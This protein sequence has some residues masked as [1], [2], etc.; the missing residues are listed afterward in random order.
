MKYSRFEILAMI[1]GI[2][3]V[4]GTAASSSA[5][6]STASEI[7]GQVLILVALFA[8]L[9]YGRKGALAGFLC[10]AVIYTILD[11]ATHSK[12]LGIALQLMVIRI[13]VYAL[14]AFVAGEL[15]ARLKYLFTKLEH[16]DYVD[17]VTSL[18]NAKYLSKLMEKYI[19]EFDRYGSQF[20][21][22]N[23]AINEEL[24]KP[25]KNKFKIK[26]IKDL[27]NSVVRGNIRGADEAARIGSTTFS[28]L[29]PNTNF[30]GAT[31][32]TIR[33]KGKIASFLDRHGLDSESEGAIKTEIHEYPKD[34]E[35]IETLAVNLAQGKPS[36]DLE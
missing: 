15:N 26:L 1:V 25:L 31:C 33:I 5:D 7:I 13:I 27:G 11:F 32:A 28:V 35:T 21:L 6:T 22:V 9:H 24:F 34:K 19:S 16:H 30:D 8:G 20:S 3:A 17:D 36:T 12:D 2:A 14:V 10:A 29:F 23:F 4:I 18:Y